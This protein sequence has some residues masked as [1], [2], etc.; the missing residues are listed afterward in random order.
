M[1][2]LNL[3]PGTLASE[4]A[5]ES[6]LKQVGFASRR[7]CNME[8]ISGPPLTHLENGAINDTDITSR[9]ENTESQP[10]PAHSARYVC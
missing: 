1:Y 8:Q 10:S 7:L 6:Q 9:T 2:Q 5:V 4:P 3:C